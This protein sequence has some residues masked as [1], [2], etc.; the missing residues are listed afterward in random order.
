MKPVSQGRWHLTWAWAIVPGLSNLLLSQ[1]YSLDGC[2]KSDCLSCTLTFVCVCGG[3]GEY[4]NHFDHFSFFFP[5]SRCY[6]LNHIIFFFSFFFPLS[7]HNSVKACKFCCYCVLRRHFR[8][9]CALTMCYFLQGLIYEDASSRSLP[10]PEP[11]EQEQH[12]HPLP[13]V[14]YPLPSL[15]HRLCGIS[16][17]CLNN[18]LS[19][20]ICDMLGGGWRGGSGDCCFR[21]TYW[22]VFYYISWFVQR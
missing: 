4:L 8:G 14:T 16:G 21:L 6:I 13:H 11:L 5:L 1:E 19:S 12:R 18:L 7:F 2:V 22:C 20:G 9:F 10:S 3:G 17:R 15:Q